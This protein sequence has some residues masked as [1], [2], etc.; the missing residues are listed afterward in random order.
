M[1]TRQTWVDGSGGATPINASRL[2]H[3]EDGIYDAD[4][5]VLTPTGVKTGS[6]AAQPG[7]LV[8]FD[9]T[10]GGRTLTLP[11][12]PPDKTRVAAKVVLGTVGVGGVLTNTLLVQAGGTD[13]FN[14][15]GG[16][17]S[18]TLNTLN[19][20]VELQYQS[21][22]GIWLVLDDSFAV[23]ALQA[24]FLLATNPVLT[25]GA[26][27]D[28]T[29]G[30]ATHTASQGGSGVGDKIALYGGATNNYGLGIQANRLVAYTPAI[31]AF[32]VRALSGTGNA[33]SGSDAAVLYPNGKLALPGGVAPTVAAGA[34][35]GTIPPAP[36]LAANSRDQRGGATFGT[37]TTP[38]VGAQLVVTFNSAFP[39]APFVQITETTGPTTALGPYVSAVSTT[40][41][42]VS[43]NTAPAA[44]QPNTAYGISWQAV[45]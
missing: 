15:A 35:A 17:T 41:F 5:A 6:Y 10:S 18:V 36:V 27:L 28:L 32:A 1:Y 40:G 11:S 24:M 4:T 34:N 21:A 7:E 19:Q 22:G 3:M 8:P 23:A 12:T 42:T 29:S 2:A 9:T 33:S 16:V 37:G 14:R 13:V 31:G 25:A 45:A 20:L 44:S 38:A 26:I 30:T 43:F 39:I